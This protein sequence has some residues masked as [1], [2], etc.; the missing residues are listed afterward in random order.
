V[1]ALHGFAL[2]GGLEL[3]LACRYRVAVGDCEA[4]A[5]L[6][7]VLLG[8]HPGFGGT[9]RSVRLL[10]VRPA[11]NL[12]LTGRSVRAEQA[13]KLGLVDR[14]VPNVEDWTVPHASSFAPNLPPHQ[15]PLTERALSWP[16]VRAF[17]RPALL[18]QVA[19]SARRDHYP[20][21][22]AMVDLWSKYG[23]RGDAAYTA[24]A[25]SIASL[26]HSDSARNLIRV[27]LLQE[28]LK[29]LAGKA[30]PRTEHPRDRRRGDGR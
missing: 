6:P 2:G 28:R 7:E 15:A 16:G 25:H 8:I 9:V 26:F 19:K 5:G 20:A 24:E 12:M 10:G 22:Y 4:G 1:A 13:L 21:P 14:L 3:A 17:I 27:F 29:A 23:A 11:M 30:L 18:R